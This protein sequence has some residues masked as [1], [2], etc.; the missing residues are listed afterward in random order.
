[1]RDTLE[2]L[3]AGEIGIAEAESRLAGYSTTDSARSTRRG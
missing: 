3:N 1:M 2:A